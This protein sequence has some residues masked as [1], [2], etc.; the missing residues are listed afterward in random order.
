MTVQVR[1]YLRFLCLALGG[2]ILRAAYPYEAPL[3][4]LAHALFDAIAVAGVLGF[5]IELAAQRRLIGEV[6]TELLGRIAG[7]N[8]PRSLQHTIETTIA[9]P[10]CDA[11]IRADVPLHQPARWPS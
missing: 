7:R 5:F 1:L 8:L 9:S 10:P 3:H 4:D 6:A 2:S 11:G